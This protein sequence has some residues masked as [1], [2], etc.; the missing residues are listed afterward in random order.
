MSHCNLQDISHCFCLVFIHLFHTTLSHRHIIIVNVG[1]LFGCYTAVPLFQELQWHWSQK[2]CA[3][4]IPSRKRLVKSWPHSELIMWSFDFWLCSHWPPSWSGSRARWHWPGWQTVCAD[5][6]CSAAGRAPRSEPGRAGAPAA[7]PTA[8]RRVMEKPKC[9]NVTLMR[10]EEWQRLLPLNMMSR[11]S[12][13]Q[14]KSSQIWD[15]FLEKGRNILE[16]LFTFLLMTKIST[17]H[18]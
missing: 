9:V 6:R 12:D 3:C 8:G 4:E 5:A 2:L 18:K 14:S 16:I 10:R 15:N 7:W 13:V 11:F 1:I 17:T